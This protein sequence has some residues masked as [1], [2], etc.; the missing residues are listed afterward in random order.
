MFISICFLF[1]NNFFK[2]NVVYTDKANL[3]LSIPIDLIIIKL[4]VFIIIVII[5]PKFKQNKV[6]CKKKK[7]FYF[8]GGLD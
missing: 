4:F 1:L 6:N 2:L 7:R 3:Y 8:I 5:K